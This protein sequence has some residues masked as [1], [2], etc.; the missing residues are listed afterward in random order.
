LFERLSGNDRCDVY[1]FHAR[2]GWIVAALTEVFGWMWPIRDQL[3]QN[4]YRLPSPGL[5]QSGGG[6]RSRRRNLAKGKGRGM[7]RGADLRPKHFHHLQAK[8]ALLFFPT[9]FERRAC[10]KYSAAHQWQG[11]VLRQAVKEK[12]R[13]AVH[14]PYFSGPLTTLTRW[15]QDQS[16]ARSPTIF[17]ETLKLGASNAF[18]T[19]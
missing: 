12:S 4:T 13:P 10:G 17:R 15:R 7:L 14:G 9:G 1:P 3:S 11:W 2:C 19:R 8:A 18:V 6:G 5:R 16:S